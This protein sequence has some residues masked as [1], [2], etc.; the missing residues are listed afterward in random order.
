[1]KMT[2]DNTQFYLYHTLGCHLC[3]EAEAVLEPLMAGL[4][5][6]YIKVDIADEDRLVDVYGVRIPVLVHCRSGL[7]LGWPFDQVQAHAFLQACL[8]GACK[9]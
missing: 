5:C 1:M 6:R 8:E 7:E 9:Y 3:E 2:A 4:Q